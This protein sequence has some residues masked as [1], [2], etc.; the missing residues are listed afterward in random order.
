MPGIYHVAGTGVTTWLGLAEATFA[1]WARRGHRVP[2][3]DPVRLA[4]WSS[5]ARRPYYS[6]LDNGKLERVFGIRMPRWQ[7]SLEVCLDAI[8]RRETEMR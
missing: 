3:I 2:R 1:G 5:P 7:E 4:D 6:A 8:A